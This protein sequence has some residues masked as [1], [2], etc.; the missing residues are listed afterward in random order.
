M[1][2]ASGHRGRWPGEV[3]PLGRQ[4]SRFMYEHVLPCHP[5]D[6]HTVQVPLLPPD[7]RRRKGRPG[8]RRL[9]QRLAAHERRSEDVN[10]GSPRRPP[11]SS[12]T[13]SGGLQGPRYR[14]APPPQPLSIR[15]HL[16]RWFGCGRG[17]K[18]VSREDLNT[19]CQL[20]PRHPDDEASASL[21]CLSPG[22]PAQRSD[23]LFPAC[24]CLRLLPTPTV[25]G[26]RLT[27]MAEQNK[28]A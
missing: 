10:A 16:S 25:P 23:S 28:L 1:G 21:A 24:L 9:A 4:R 6:S 14:M 8:V 3:A 11:E 20:P 7:F 13:A 18:F 5:R 15:G 19:L 17:E 27:V 12:V 26:S 2:G 22:L